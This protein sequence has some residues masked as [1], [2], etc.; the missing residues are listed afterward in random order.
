MIL[1]A[2]VGVVYVVP[3]DVAPYEKAAQER[4]GEKVRIG[5]IQIRPLPAPYL[6]MEKVSIGEAG[7]ERR[8]QIASVKAVPEFGSIFGARKVFKSVEMAGISLPQGMVGGAL[9]G[10][11]RDD[12][13]RIGRVVI[14]GLKLDL[15]GMVVPPLDVDASF[16][17]SGLEKARLVNDEKGVSVSLKTNGAQTDIEIEAKTLELPFA[18]NIAL[19]DFLAKGALDAQQLTLRE[20]EARAFDG[21]FAGSARVSWRGAWDFSGAFEARAMDAAKLA[22][23]I[24]STGTLEGKGVYSMKSDL[25]EKLVASARIEGT[26]K[27]TKGSIAGVDLTQMLR[28]ARV[29]GGSSLFS[30]MTG[31]AVAEP[32]G[33]QLRQIRF[34]AGLLSA[35]GS[36]DLDPQQNLS[37]RLE[38]ELRSQAR[39]TVA[40]SG[41]L[42]K[43]VFRR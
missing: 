17:T 31:T 34:S 2:A 14:R 27:V 19:N 13:L 12:A 39:A 32:R 41:T 22:G 20:F 43:P 5:S 8:L 11:G 30:E 35:G 16:G 7:A 40:I 3:I 26:F 9:W 42:A 29:T 37:G 38:V 18:Q 10:K 15:K 21:I 25:P 33:I 6:S 24:V 1:V 36:V 23:P 28:G 4:F